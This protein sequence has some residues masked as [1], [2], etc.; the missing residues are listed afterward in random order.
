[1]PR[2]ISN[3]DSYKDKVYKLIPG[4]VAA[5]Y[6]FV[7]VVLENTRLIFE[8]KDYT[9]VVQ[10][11]F[12]LIIIISLPVYLVQYHK[13]MRG[14]QLVLTTIGF[15]LGAITLNNEF[16]LYGAPMLVIWIFISPLL[17]RNKPTK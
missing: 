2:E 3:E 15:L 4:E 11:I 5:F 9:G 17:I 1:M 16:S 6:F 12:F 7:I 10:F 14:R 13:V 8:N